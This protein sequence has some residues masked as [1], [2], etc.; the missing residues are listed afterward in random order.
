[1]FVLLSY[2]TSSL[3]TYLYVYKLDSPQEVSKHYVI[4][5]SQQQFIIYCMSKNFDVSTHNTFNKST[6]P[7]IAIL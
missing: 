3:Y 7:N 4:N 2:I 6:Q 1:M 5:Q